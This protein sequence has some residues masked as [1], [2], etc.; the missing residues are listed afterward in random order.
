MCRT[1]PPLLNERHYGVLQMLNRAKVSRLPHRRSGQGN[2]RSPRSAS[3]VDK[4][5]GQGGSRSTPCPITYAAK[6]SMVE[7][8]EMTLTVLALACSVF[9]SVTVRTPSLY[10]ASTLSVSTSLGSTMS[11]RKIPKRRSER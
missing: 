2:S 6:T 8:Y 5:A 3:A 4:H 1:N 7:V 10:A 11:L 9:G